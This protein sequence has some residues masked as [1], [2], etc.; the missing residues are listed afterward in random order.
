MGKLSFEL[1]EGNLRGLRVGGVEVIRA[2]QYLVRDSG[3]GTMI[4]Q[5]VDLSVSENAS[6]AEVRYKAR[7][8][9]PDG[10]RLDYEASIVAT[11]NSLDFSVT[12][13]ALDDLKTN[14]LGFCVLHPAALAGAGLTVEHGDGRVERA[15]FPDL[16]EPSQP[17]TDIA[18]MIHEQDGITVICRLSGDSFEME[19]QRNWSD[20]SYKTYVRPLAKPWPYVVPAGSVDRQSVSIAVA[21]QADCPAGG[22][23]EPVELTMG[24]SIGVMP[25]IGLV[26]TP[27]DARA[28]AIH[29]AAFSDLGVQDLLLSLAAHRGEGLAELAAFAHGVNDLPQR[30][31]LECVIPGGE[32]PHAELRDVAAQV[33]DAGLKLDAIA[34]YPAPDLMSTPPGSAWPP[35]PA[36][37]D[38][39]A[40]ARAAFPGLPVGGGTFAYF[41]ELNRKHPPLGSVDFVS[42]ATCPIVHAADDLSVMQSLEAIPA[43]LRSGRAIIGDKPYRLGPV[44]IAMRHNPYGA[45]AKANPE[46]A[47]IPMADEDPRQDGAFAAAWTIGYAAMTGAA[48][49]DTLTFG[50]LTGPRG[51]IGEGG[52]RPV[53]E[54]VKA[55]AALAGA[56][57]HACGSSAPQR[58]VGLAAGGRV[59]AVNLTAAVQTVRA[60]SGL[61]TLEPFAFA[62]VQDFSALSGCA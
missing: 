42:H 7:C 44:T 15:C 6:V 54:A 29:R 61:L 31:T 50:A 28:M 25:R 56:A 5:I 51:V 1:V 27:E 52:R 53:F 11:G 8:S 62:E 3:W 39:Y 47:R 37:A 41:T 9:S 12:A 24:A 23:G 30:R 35:C 58:V 57:R 38:V 45:A 55:L 22:G 43:I 49:L 13:C 60:G 46:G 36:L 34:V 40:A 2:V 4:P 33:A 21:G 19:D 17:F 59:I 16:I 32:D 48:R 20:A 10:A 18:E 14:R 26:L